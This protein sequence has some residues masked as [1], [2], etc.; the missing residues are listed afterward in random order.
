MLKKVANI[1]FGIVAGISIL[2]MIYLY[3]IP[4]IWPNVS[5]WIP[6]VVLVV[7]VGVGVMFV[8]RRRRGRYNRTRM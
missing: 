8:V 5:A 2:F 6:T 3:V 4:A 1:I 7:V